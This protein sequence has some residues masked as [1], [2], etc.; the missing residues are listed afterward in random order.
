MVLYQLSPARNITKVN[1]SSKYM[2]NIC[3][4]EIIIKNELVNSFYQMLITTILYNFT[5]IWLCTLHPI[6]LH[7]RQIFNYYPNTLVV[8]VLSIVCGIAKMELCS[9]NKNK[10]LF[11]PDCD[12][13]KSPLLLP[14]HVKLTEMIDRRSMNHT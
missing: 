7:E 3:E 11:I 4:G 5:S 8:Y 9:K 12:F 10:D 6:Y 13:F 2:S 14:V 1:K